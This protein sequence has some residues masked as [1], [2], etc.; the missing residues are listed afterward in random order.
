MTMAR[1]LADRIQQLPMARRRKVESRA[2]EVI[3]EDMPLHDLRR[4]AIR[5][6]DP[7]QPSMIRATTRSFVISGRIAMDVPDQSREMAVL[8]QTV[9]DQTVPA[10]S[11]Q[12]S[13]GSDP[14]SHTSMP[15]SAAV[16]YTIR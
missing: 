10:Q 11:D 5:D 2:K 9:L 3:A 16:A 14:E 4:A 8:D 1:T 13:P 7:G 12:P 6:S 15:G